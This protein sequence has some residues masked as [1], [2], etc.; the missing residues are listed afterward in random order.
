[1]ATLKYATTLR[2]A[3]QDA[4]ATFAGNSGILR[5]YA[6]TMPTDPQTSIGS[7]VLL[8]ELTMNA[9]AF[10]AAS[11]GVLTAN[12]ITQDSSANAT[13]TASFFRLVKSDTTTV[14]MDGDITATGGGGAMTLNTVS[15]V[16]G[17]PISCTGFTI[18]RGN[19]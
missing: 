13:N 14:V 3:Q 17:G 7:Q 18:T 9:T 6:G 8:G 16:S 19:A 15:I 10:S 4:I 11:N 2:N 12:A 1:M 5:I